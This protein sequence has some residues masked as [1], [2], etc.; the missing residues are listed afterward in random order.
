MLMSPSMA[1][2]AETPPVVGWVSTD[3]Y[4]RPASRRRPSAAEVLAICI[5]DNRPSCMRA[6]PLAE[7]HTNG[8]PICSAV[9]AASAKRSPTTEPIEPPMKAKSNEA[10][11]SGCAL[12]RPCI[13]ISASY[14]PVLFCEILMRSLYFFWSLN[15]SASVGPR[16]API[17][18]GVVSGSNS[19]ARRARAR[20]AMWW[21]HFGQ[22][23]RFSSSSGRYSTALQLGHFSHRPSGTLRFLLGVLSV[24]MPEG[25]NLL[26]QL[27]RNDDPVAR[28]T[29]PPRGDSLA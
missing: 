9:S 10:A 6:P 28:P 14:S 26:S 20:I 19:E 13:A 21:P 18:V 2:L 4:G 27:M 7:K 12:S 22:T 8:A 15:F 25:I 24:R 1:K 23:S 17:S 3:T 11:T 29:G 16:R 5:S